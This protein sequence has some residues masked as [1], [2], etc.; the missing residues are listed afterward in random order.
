MSRGKYYDMI[1]KFN[2]YEKYMMTRLMTM[3]EYSGLPEEIPQHLAESYIQNFGKALFLKHED[4]YYILFGEFGGVPNAYYIPQ[5]FIIAN[6]Y[7]KLNKKFK[8]GVD[9]VLIKN[10]T[11]MVGLRKLNEKYAKYLNNSDITMNIANINMRIPQILNAS[12]DEAYRSAVEYLK[13]VTDGEVGVIL[14]KSSLFDEKSTQSID[15]ASRVSNNYLSQLIEMHQ[16]L[17]ASYYNEIGLQCNYNM[18]RESIGSNESDM[19]LDTLL[20]LAD[21][22]LYCRQQATKEINDLFGLSIS[23]DFSGAW[24]RHKK[25]E[26]EITEGG[27]NNV[28]QSEEDNIK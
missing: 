3:F 2:T 18:K 21:E 22:M 20:P 1:D 5:E 7:L 26:D 28:V 13:K 19:N 12:T 8:I 23:V 9:S 15:F 17:K 25:I 27:K 10:D 24:K 16:Y 6:P 4:M 14:D 11:M